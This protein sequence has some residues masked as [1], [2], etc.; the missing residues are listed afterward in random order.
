MPM[1]VFPFVDFGFIILAI[2]IYVLRFIFI[3]FYLFL[4]FLYGNFE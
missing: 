4:I 3:A 1:V 2:F